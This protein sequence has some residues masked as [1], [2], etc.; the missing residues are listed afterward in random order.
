[1]AQLSISTTTDLDA[2]GDDG[3]AVPSPRQLAVGVAA[4]VALLFALLF[5]FSSPEPDRLPN[6]VQRAVPAD[7][8]L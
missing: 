1:V 5:T 2:A 7:R 3:P 8:P 6:E 4:I